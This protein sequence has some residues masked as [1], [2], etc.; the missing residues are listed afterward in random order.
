MLDFLKT[1]FTETSLDTL[2]VIAGLAFLGIAVVG[3]VT[4][5]ITPG[6]G[7]RIASGLLGPVLIAIGLIIHSAGHG[8][9]NPPEEKTLATIRLT[10]NPSRATVFL[11]GQK[12]G[13][14]E[15]GTLILG[16]LQPRPFSVR[17]I[18]DG[19]TPWEQAVELHA[20]QEIALLAE[21]QRILSNDHP[22]SGRRPEPPEASASRKQPQPPQSG[23]NMPPAT[24]SGT[25]QSGEYT[26]RL[27]QDGDKV[28]SEGSF[29]HADGHF[30]GPNTFSLTW[31]S[32]A[33]TGNVRRDTIRWNNNTSWTRQRVN[34]SGTWQSGEYT[35]RLAQDG[36]KVI[37]EGSFGHA[38]GH[39]TGPNTFSLTWESG[40][41][42][43]NVRGDTIYWS[44][45]TSW[46]RHAAGQK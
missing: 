30:T 6:R 34:V 36:D 18:K 28:I 42:T 27:A 40:A 16:N 22:T 46:T 25:W 2:F 35:F 8:S 15:Q 38:D 37:S 1:L 5:K 19:Y 44:N 13:T 43:G 32:G 14:T 24:V 11:D 23:T 26:F 7:G 31:A 4:G 41:F 29:G 45:N 20:G 21:L 12:V 10:S 39:F 3:N 17:V 9:P 33:F